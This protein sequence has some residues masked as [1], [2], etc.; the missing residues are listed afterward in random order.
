M[1]WI[2][3]DAMGGDYAPG[4]VVDGALAAARHF[5]LGV[6]LVGPADVLEAE[7]KR[8]TVRRPGAHPHHRRA[9]RRGDGRVARRRRCGASRGAS[10]KVAA[11]AVARGDAAAL[12]SAGHTGATVMAAHGA[13]GMLPGVDRPAL[14][15][16]IPTRQRPAVL[17]DVGASVECRPQHLLQFAV[18]G[19]RYA[20]VAFGIES[21]RVGLLSI[22]E[23]ATKGNELT[24]EAHQL[25][26]AAPLK[27]IGNIEARD[28]YSGEADVIVCDG[29]TG[30]VALKISE[31]LVDV[32][33]GLL[34]RRIVEH[35]HHAGRIAAD[36][37]GAAALPAPR[38]L[39]RVRRRA[40]ARRRR[41]RP[42]SATG[43]RAPRR[44]ATRS[45][46][47]IVLRTIASSSASSATSPRPPRYPTSDRLHLSRTGFAESRHGQG[48]RR[49]V[50]RSAARPSTRPTPRSA[51]RSAA[52]CFDGPEDQLTLT[53]NTQPAILAV[54]IAAYRLLESR[55]HDAGV[56]RRPQPRRVF[57]ERRRRHVRLRRR[58][59]ARAAARPL[60]AGGR[61]GRRRRDGGDPRPRRRQGRA[62]VRRGGRGRGRQP[63]EHER[64]R[65]GRD[66]RRARRGRSAPASAPRR[67]ARSGWCRS[68]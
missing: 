55:G 49:G 25:L 10:I 27:F 65:P 50:S 24:R 36:A 45:R 66:R 46:W 48:A 34:K 42:S 38:R 67:S 61:A 15:A 52:S 4:H 32:I 26:K 16:T 33:E 18:M 23:E 11:E 62:G 13:F 47:P 37:P 59:A 39:L 35:D 56:R 6:A 58:A 54:S 57:G 22:G 63:G 8:Q 21:P 9:R 14:A 17:L 31:G 64:R 19:S 41:R 28:V 60:H 20:R 43:G 29:F 51:S 40:A 30:N 5:D 1:L 7:L 68:P 12:F 44:C 2:A 3:V 53:E